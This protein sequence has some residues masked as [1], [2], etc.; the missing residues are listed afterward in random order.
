MKTCKRCA[1]NKSASEFRVEA[2]N[3]D[4]LSSWCIEC[5]AAASMAHYQANK[6][7]RNAAARA[8][9]QAN[10]EKTRAADAAFKQSNKVELAKNYRT[11]A[12]KNRASLRAIDARRKAAKRQATPAWADPLAIRA[13]YADA[14]R[15]QEM[16]GTRMHVDHIVPIQSEY[17]CGLHCE[18]NL[19]VLPGAEN[20][21]KRNRWW[22]DMPRIEEAQKQA[23]LFPHE[24][25][26][27]KPQQM[28]L[29]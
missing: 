10:P 16:T 8:W 11:W 20:E 18:A 13:I 21:A 2:R 19:Q 14:V 23:A 15:L 25:P 17:V 3:Q 6:S 22:P 24:E 1:M 28:V 12:E 5:H 29:E 9:A 4:R 7:A 26:V 27:A